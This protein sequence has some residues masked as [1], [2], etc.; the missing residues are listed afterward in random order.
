MILENY[1]NSDGSNHNVKVTNPELKEFA[2]TKKSVNSGISLKK[3]QLNDAF[4]LCD[5]ENT[6]LI[7][8]NDAEK[9]V[10]NVMDILKVSVTGNE[11]YVQSILKEADDNSVSIDYSIWPLSI[12]SYYIHNQ[13]QKIQN[14]VQKGS[15]LSKVSKTI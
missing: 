8:L 5:E 1:Q 15:L 3:K 7:S 12:S 2:Y 4:N 10:Y 6:G 14:V 9:A 13:I 11:E